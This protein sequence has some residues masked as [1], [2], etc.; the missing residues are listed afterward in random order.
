[1]AHSGRGA[2]TVGPR[3]GTL[4]GSGNHRGG[5]RPPGANVGCPRVPA[6]GRPTVGVRDLL[7]T[8]GQL[9]PRQ[10]D[11]ANWTAAERSSA[12]ALDEAAGS[13]SRRIVTV[14]ARPTFEGP[15][16]RCRYRR[17]SSG[18][19]SGAWRPRRDRGGA[20]QG[21]TLERQPGRCAWPCSRRRQPAGSLAAVAGRGHAGPRGRVRRHGRT[22]RCQHADPPF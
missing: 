3:Q 6:G 15:H 18:L 4:R 16:L 22:S 2:D 21:G 13:I 20:S 19:P 17:V 9:A 10:L 1:M 7:L 8:V 11:L 5:A 12:A 14:C